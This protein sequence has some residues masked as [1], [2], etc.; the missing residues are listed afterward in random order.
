[1]SLPSLVPL[2]AAGEL[3][4]LRRAPALLPHLMGCGLSLEDAAALA[5]NATLL[6]FAL[7]DPQITSPRKVLERFT[8]EEIAAGARQ[9]A[10]GRQGGEPW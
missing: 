2:S 1:M 6:Y 8:L 7:Q 5:H 3:A 9:L 4:V 10:E